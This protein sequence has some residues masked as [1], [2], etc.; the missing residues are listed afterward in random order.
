MLTLLVL[1][2]ITLLM[3]VFLIFVLYCIFGRRNSPQNCAVDETHATDLPSRDVEAPV[4]TNCP[5]FDALSY[6]DTPMGARDSSVT[7]PHPYKDAP[8]HP[9]VS[10]WPTKPVLTLTDSPISSQAD[11]GKVGVYLASPK[12]VAGSSPASRLQTPTKSALAGPLFLDADAIHEAMRG[13]FVSTLG[14]AP[15]ALAHVD[16]ERVRFDA[17]R[18]SG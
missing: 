15:I 13:A 1:G 10:H 2:G 8:W 7:A 14:G 12:S 4:I 11:L 18:R 6:P 3:I 16:A 17:P 9:D 5:D